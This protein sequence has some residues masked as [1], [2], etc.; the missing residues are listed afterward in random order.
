M[1]LG[2]GLDKLQA[3]SIFEILDIC[4]DVRDLQREAKKKGGKLR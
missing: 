4:E 3:L 2:M 1:N